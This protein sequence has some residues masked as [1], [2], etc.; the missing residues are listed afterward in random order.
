MTSAKPLW[1][2]KP[3]PTS[4]TSD[5]DLNYL[6]LYLED[7]V[8]ADQRKPQIQKGKLPVV[9][10]LQSSTTP[11]R[12]YLNGLEWDGT[13]RIRYAHCPTS[14]ELQRD[15]R[16]APM[17]VMRLFHAGRHSA[18]CSEPGCKFETDALLW[19]ADR[20]RESPPSSGCWLCKDEWF[21]DDL[22]TN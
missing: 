22:K 9:A 6:M 4:A 8:R 19:S 14:S 20:G 17:N 12:E 18:G 13:E 2:S 7:R 3:T 11:I 10:D 16:M 5:T 15:A 21:S 1:W